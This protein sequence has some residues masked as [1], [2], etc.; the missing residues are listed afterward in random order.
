MMPASNSTQEIHKAAQQILKKIYR[1]GFHYK[2]A[3]ILLLDLCRVEDS[4]DTLFHAPRARNTKLI[5]SFDVI[6]QKFGAGSIQYGQL[7]RPKGWYAPQ[8]YRSPHFTTSWA[9][10]PL[11]YASDNFFQPDD[12]RAEV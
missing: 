10:I 3:G 5:E 4:P 9:D 8:K 7:K 2:K 12:A 1:S 6:N 11:A